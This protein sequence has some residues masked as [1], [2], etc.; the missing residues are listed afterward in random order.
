MAGHRTGPRLTAGERAAA[1]LRRRG[2]A[3][4]DLRLHAHAFD[5]VIVRT[6]VLNAGS[7]GMPFGGP[8]RAG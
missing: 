5:C 4:G 1:D 6:R 8:A 7:V 3:A 2:C